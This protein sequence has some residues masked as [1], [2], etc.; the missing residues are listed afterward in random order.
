MSFKRKPQDGYLI[1][2]ICIKLNKHLQLPLTNKINE[3]SGVRDLL[4]KWI[5]KSVILIRFH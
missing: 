1:I 4:T 5:M 3:E 2:I